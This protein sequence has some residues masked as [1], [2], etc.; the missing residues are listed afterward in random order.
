MLSIWKAIRNKF[1]GRSQQRETNWAKADDWEKMWRFVIASP[2]AQRRMFLTTVALKSKSNS[3]GMSQGRSECEGKADRRQHRASV[4]VSS[5]WALRRAGWSAARR[6]PRRLVH[7]V[8]VQPACLLVI[9]RQA[10]LFTWTSYKCLCRCV[11]LAEATFSCLAPS[12]TSQG[13]ADR[14]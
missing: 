10:S 2:A 13:R 4:E 1:L 12:Q 8:T 14:Q 6:K 11:L 5:P 9:S 7:G 3:A